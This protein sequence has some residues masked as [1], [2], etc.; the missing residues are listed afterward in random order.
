MAYELVVTRRW[1]SDPFS[2]AGRVAMTG[3]IV[4]GHAVGYYLAHRWMH[5]RAMYWAHRFHHRFNT[6][7]RPPTERATACRILPLSC[8]RLIEQMSSP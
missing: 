6:C 7:A 3:A 1:M 8:F 5:T 2:T 4:L